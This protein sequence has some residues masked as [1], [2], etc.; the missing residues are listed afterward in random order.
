MLIL[1]L[2]LGLAVGLITMSIV[3]IMALKRISKLEKALALLIIEQF[4]G[5]KSRGLR[6]TM[7]GGQDHDP[8]KH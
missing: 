3:Q 7:G 4:T 6:F 5:T 8:T 2:I 1:G